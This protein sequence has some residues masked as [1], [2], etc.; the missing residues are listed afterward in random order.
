VLICDLS[1]VD[2]LTG[3]MLFTMVVVSA[4]LVAAF[5]SLHIEYACKK[6]WAW[7]GRRHV[8]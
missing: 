5:I 1:A 2:D 3:F 4:L 6:L 8:R 7:W